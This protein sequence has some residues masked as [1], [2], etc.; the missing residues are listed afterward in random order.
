MAEP[1]IALGKKMPAKTLTCAFLDLNTGT[2]IIARKYKVMANKLTLI[3]F[4]NKFYCFIL[5]FGT[6][7]TLSKQCYFEFLPAN[8]YWAFFAH[9]GF[10][11]TFF[12][13]HSKSLATGGT[14]IRY[15]AN[16][17][18]WIKLVVFKMLYRHPLTSNSKFT[19]QIQVQ[20]TKYWI[21]IYQ[22]K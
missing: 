6:K 22:H 2:I 17:P 7:L 12:A 10:K 11:S 19:F 14:E 16:C 18:T 20:L 9:F 15:F 5:Y 1:L 21:L 3:R 4:L 13:R 8:L